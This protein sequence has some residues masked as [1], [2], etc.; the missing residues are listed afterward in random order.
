[1]RFSRAIFLTSVVTVC[2]L[3]A[4]AVVFWLLMPIQVYVV[5]K[6]LAFAE[7]TC[8]LALT[9]GVRVVATWLFRWRAI[10]FLMPGA[11]LEAVVLSA[12]YGLGTGDLALLVVAFSANS[13]VA[14]EI[15]R[16]LG[17]HVY[18]DR[19]RRANW[20]LVMMAGGLAAFANAAILSQLD[21]GFSGSGI[22]A[23]VTA[24]AVIGG[25]AGLFVWLLLLRAVLRAA[26]WMH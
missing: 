16:I 1:M 7:V 5:S 24:N 3:F 14:F 4:F 25:S 23:W 9:H 21:F 26:A 2:Y 15:L 8:L 10:L 6:Y 20:R 22:I 12:H 18:A 17:W 19:A 13:F 11:A